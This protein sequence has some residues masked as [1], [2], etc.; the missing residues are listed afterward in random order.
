MKIQTST[1]NHLTKFNYCTTV[2]FFFLVSV[3][4]IHRCTVTIPRSCGNSSGYLYRYKQ[5]CKPFWVFPGD[6]SV[7]EPACQCWR[8]KRHRFNPWAGSCPGKGNGSPLQCS[9]QENSTDRGVWQATVPTVAKSQT[10]L[11]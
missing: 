11:K 2:V 1:Y 6:S 5:S 7:K 4:F 3:Q 8:C 9:C 10:G